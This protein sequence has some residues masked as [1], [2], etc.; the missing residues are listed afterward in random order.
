MIS[1]T[2]YNHDQNLSPQLS[3]E[4]MNDTFPLLACKAPS[5]LTE[6]EK[7]EIDARLGIAAH[8]SCLE[9]PR[10]DVATVEGGISNADRSPDELN[11]FQLQGTEKVQDHDGRLAI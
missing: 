1:S 7:S 2:T 11:R 5:W 4:T 8:E 3:E 10:S 9:R 6:H